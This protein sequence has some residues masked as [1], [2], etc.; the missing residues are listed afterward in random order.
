MNGFGCA[1]SWGFHLEFCIL[2]ILSAE[3]VDK[4][5]AELRVPKGRNAEKTNIHFKIETFMCK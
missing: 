3:Y 2:I 5:W 4:P 1:Q